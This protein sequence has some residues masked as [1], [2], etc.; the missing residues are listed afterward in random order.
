[1][2]EF[3]GTLA[4]W[5]DDVRGLPKCTLVTLMKL[6]ARVAH[7]IPAGATSLRTLPK[8]RER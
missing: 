2:H 7:F 1:M 8:S 6:G 4:H 5:Y 3:I